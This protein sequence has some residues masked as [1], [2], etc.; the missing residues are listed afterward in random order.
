MKFLELLWTA[1]RRAG[2]ASTGTDQP[3]KLQ[4]SPH[5][6]GERPQACFTR[7]K[8]G[9]ISKD[10]EVTQAWLTHN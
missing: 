9:E 4:F 6:R 10:N 7:F 3:D 5:S 2:V 1:Q 8:R